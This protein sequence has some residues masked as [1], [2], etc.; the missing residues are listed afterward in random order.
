[1]DSLFIVVITKHDNHDKF[2]EVEQKLVDHF[3]Y[4]D[5]YWRKQ[6]N[7][8]SVYYKNVDVVDHIINNYWRY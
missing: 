8:I 2:N 3:G 7:T 1:M 6:D 4:N 5:A